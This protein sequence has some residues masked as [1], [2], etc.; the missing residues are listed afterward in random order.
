MDTFVGLV[1]LAIT[2]AIVIWAILAFVDYLDDQRS[3]HEALERAMAVERERAATERAMA[4]SAAA[5]LDQ[6]A[7]IRGRTRW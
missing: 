4:Q 7:R 5:T 1:F 2:I 6:M 3:A